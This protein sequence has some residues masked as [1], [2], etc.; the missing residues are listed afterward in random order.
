MVQACS[1]WEPTVE[2]LQAC[3][4]TLPLPVCP[5]PQL[6]QVLLQLVAV[7]QSEV[8]KEE[9]VAGQLVHLLLAV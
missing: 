3:L 2:L 1:A 9:D 4:A 5:G 8:Q 7:G 6:L